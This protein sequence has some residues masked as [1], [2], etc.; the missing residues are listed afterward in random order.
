M[1]SWTDMEV[2]LIHQAWKSVGL[3]FFLSV[4]IWCKNL[5]L[6]ILGRSICVIDA[7]RWPLDNFSLLLLVD[8]FHL[9]VLRHRVFWL[10]GGRPFA[11]GYF[12]LLFSEA[13][14]SFEFFKF[15]HFLSRIFVRIE[16]Y[17]HRNGRQLVASWDRPIFIIDHSFE[18]CV[19]HA[20]WQWFLHRIVFLNAKALLAPDLSPSDLI[21]IVLVKCVIETIIGIT[22]KP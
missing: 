10:G 22:S 19:L 16:Y 15:T 11:L 12:S 8:R 1:Q 13:L 5:N 18:V 7:M 9:T 20:S 21:F 14:S 4:I 3:C 17:I 6:R 2:A